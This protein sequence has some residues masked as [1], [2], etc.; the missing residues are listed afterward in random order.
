TP[1]EGGS[2]LT[3]PG[4]VELQRVLRTLVDKGVD[5]LAI[6]ASSHA[7]DQHR[8]DGLV[9]EVAVFTNLSRDHLDYHRTMDAYRD[10]K[11][12][13]LDY[14]A[15]HGIVVTNLDDVTW[16]SLNTERRKLGFSVRVSSEVHAE[17]IEYSPTGSRWTL[18]LPGQ[19]V[20]TRLPLIGDFNV[21]NALPPAAASSATGSRPTLIATRPRSL[22]RAP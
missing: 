22:P 13:L 12:R 18:A 8:V 5:F 4:A 21:S 1:M 6:E 17:D 16:R 11:A 15:P 20:E 14:L 9:F 2:G 7:L 10:A 19:S 3:T